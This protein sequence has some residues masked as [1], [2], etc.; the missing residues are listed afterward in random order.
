MIR[1]EVSPE[2]IF[3]ASQR[4]WWWQQDGASVHCTDTVIDFLDAMF[5]GWVITW[6]REHPMA[7]YNPDLPPLSYYFWGLPN[8]EGWRQKPTTI[9]APKVVVEQVAASLC[10]EV[11]YVVMQNVKVCLHYEG[12]TLRIC[13]RIFLID[14]S[15]TKRQWIC[16]LHVFVKMSCDD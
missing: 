6:R 1:D 3:R 16:N 11:D 13:F 12:Q 5:W 2:V 4:Q 8:A 10:G 9:N 14:L 15:C 7:T